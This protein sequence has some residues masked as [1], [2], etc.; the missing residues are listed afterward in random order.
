M[1]QNFF[2]NLSDKVRSI[3]IE[4]YGGLAGDIGTWLLDNLPIINLSKLGDGSYIA[5]IRKV[6]KNIE[7]CNFAT[8]LMILGATTAGVAG[9]WSVGWRFASPVKILKI[10]VDDQTTA[11][12]AK[13]TALKVMGTPLE[14]NNGAVLI[15]GTPSLPTALNLGTEDVTAQL[16]ISPNKDFI[17]EGTCTTTDTIVVTLYCQ[18]LNF[19]VGV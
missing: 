19:Q 5:G 7:K 8:D 3:A 16:I 17:I 13:I 2:P 14:F 11:L 9:V 12:V 1:R 18:D 6:L 10:V 15:T 4:A